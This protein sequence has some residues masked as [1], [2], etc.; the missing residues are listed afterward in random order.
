V[1]KEGK[2]KPDMP[3]GKKRQKKVFQNPENCTTNNFPPR[4]I[5]DSMGVEEKKQQTVS[6]GHWGK[7]FSRQVH[8]KKKR[9]TNLQRQNRPEGKK[10]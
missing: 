5:K 7:K 2:T 3:M 6:L 4:S 8:G 1:L 10:T 9:N